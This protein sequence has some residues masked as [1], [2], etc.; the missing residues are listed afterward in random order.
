VRDDEHDTATPGQ[1]Q[2]MRYVECAG[3]PTTMVIASPR[4]E[5]QTPRR[6]AGAG[7]TPRTRR[8]FPPG[9]HTLPR[10]WKSCGMPPDRTKYRSRRRRGCGRRSRIAGGKRPR[11]RARARTWTHAS[12]RPG[13]GR[14][15]VIPARLGT[16]ADCG[17]AA[18]GRRAGS[19]PASPLNVCSR[20]WIRCAEC[21]YQSGGRGLV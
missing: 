12:S 1:D 6:S 7:C 11:Q 5:R 17:R 19:R 10:C 18:R 8:S 16:A 15:R 21:G 3:I 14:A 9:R 4:R 20:R 13:P 2:L